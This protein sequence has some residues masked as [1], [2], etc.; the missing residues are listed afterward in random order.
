MWCDA[1]RC[2]AMRCFRGVLLSLIFHFVLL[3]RKIMVRDGWEFDALFAA[4]YSQPLNYS[5]WF[6]LNNPKNFDLTINKC[7]CTIHK[8]HSWYVNLTSFWTLTII[9]FLYPLPF[10][11]ILFLIRRLAL[12]LRWI[13]PPPPGEY[14]ALYKTNGLKIVGGKEWRIKR[15]V[16]TSLFCQG[17]A[18]FR[19]CAIP[20]RIVELDHSQEETQQR[21]WEW[22]NERFSEVRASVWTYLWTLLISISSS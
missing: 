11:F 2:D 13:S 4:F 17:L 10:F 3:L 19:F 9:L 21:A 14:R 18:C 15:D 6:K 16:T 5:F 20:S 22:N 7:H 12:A 8:S 1:I